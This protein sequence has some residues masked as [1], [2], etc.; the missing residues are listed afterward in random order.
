[1]AAI[2]LHIFLLIFERIFL[3]LETRQ[4]LWTGVDGKAGPKDR[5]TRNQGKGNVR[6]QVD[7][8][9][10][11]NSLT[12]KLSIFITSKP[13]PNFSKARSQKP[14][15]STTRTQ[16]PL[17]KPE[18]APRQLDFLLRPSQSDGP[19]CSAQQL[20]CPAVCD[21]LLLSPFTLSVPQSRGSSMMLTL[22][23]QLRPGL[24]SRGKTP[25]S[26]ILSTS[27]GRTG[28]GDGIKALEG[29]LF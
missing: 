18:T 11:K 26:W 29:I 24:V 22:F 16:K 4:R 12:S 8:T 5:W 25:L 19:L 3:K 6:R 1:M 23:A 21:T 10:R 14:N 15:F 7:C 2:R 20:L 13:S 28:S 27:T 17:S 9:V